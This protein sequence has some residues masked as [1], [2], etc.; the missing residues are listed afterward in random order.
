MIVTF[1]QHLQMF[2]PKLC[3]CWLILTVLFYTHKWRINVS[4]FY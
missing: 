2:A 3:E 4:Y 1:L